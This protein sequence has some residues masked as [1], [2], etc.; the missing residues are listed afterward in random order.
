MI[1]FVDIV[2][3]CLIFRSTLQFRLNYTIVESS[4]STLTALNPI[5]DQTQ[6][7]RSFEASFQK[8]CGTD[9][10][11]QSQLEV[12]AELELDKEG[13]LQ[14]K[15]EFLHFSSNLLRLRLRTTNKFLE[16][17]HIFR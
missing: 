13:K 7:D 1:V 8:D 3:I 2:K 16:K 17:I 10:M 4:P 12:Y 11:C 6:A 5:L 9:D 14:K 15:M